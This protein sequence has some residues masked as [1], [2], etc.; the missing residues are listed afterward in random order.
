MEVTVSLDLY[1]TRDGGVWHHG[2][3]IGPALKGHP[4]NIPFI[5]RLDRGP[6]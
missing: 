3:S 6:S 5:A 1:A 4:S 2:R